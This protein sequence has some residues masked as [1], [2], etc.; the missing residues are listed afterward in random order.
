MQSDCVVKANNVVSNIVC[1]FRAVGIVLVSNPLYLQIQ[2]KPL[3]YR[4]C[5]VIYPAVSFAAHAADQA[6]SG[7]QRLML[8]AC[9]LDGGVL[10]S[11]HHVPAS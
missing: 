1:S 7:K 11:S 2:D 9:V 8:A 6:M 4:A 10:P 3:Y 5:F